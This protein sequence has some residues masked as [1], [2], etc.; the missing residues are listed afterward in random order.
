[1]N[2]ILQFQEAGQGGTTSPRILQSIH[3]WNRLHTH[4]IDDPFY[5]SS[6]GGAHSIRLGVLHLLEELDGHLPLVAPLT[7]ADG[8]AVAELLGAHVCD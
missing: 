5:P 2:I 8:R 3:V 7:G 6:A 1:M 4:S